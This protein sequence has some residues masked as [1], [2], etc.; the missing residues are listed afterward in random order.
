MNSS[1]V[2]KEAAHSDDSGNEDELVCEYS[3]PSDTDEDDE[4]QMDSQERYYTPMWNVNSSSVGHE[5]NNE[6]KSNETSNSIR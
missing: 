3:S 4:E 6:E 2:T 1:E 5:D